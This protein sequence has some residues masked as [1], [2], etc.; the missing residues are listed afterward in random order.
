KYS[1]TITW[2]NGGGRYTTGGIIQPLTSGSNLFAVHGGLGVTYYPEPGSYAVTVTITDVGGSSATANSTVLVADA[3]LSPIT[4]FALP[5]PNSRP[6]QIT[7]GAD[8]NLWFT[9]SAGNRIGRITPDGTL[10]E[11]SLPNP[12]SPFGITAGPDGNLWFMEFS[13]VGRITP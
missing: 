9:E 6:Y 5:T 10:T 8:G 13:R 12:G 4:E 3:P 11:F 1:A 7:A 2:D